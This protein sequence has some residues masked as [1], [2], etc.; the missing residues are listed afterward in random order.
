[1][2]ENESQYLMIAEARKGEERQVWISSWKRVGAGT[3]AAPTVLIEKQQIWEQDEPIL[4]VAF[5]PSG[6][7]VLSPGK[8]AL[9]GSGNEP[10]GSIPIPPMKPWP[11]DPRGRLRV[12]GN[13]FQAFL[14]GMRCTG[15]LEPA[16]T[17]ECKPS[18]EAWPLESGGRALILARLVAGRNYF[19]G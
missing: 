18:D 7:L 9:F 16:L 10:R 4:D 3:R 6:L 5:P 8:V 2:S 13:S 15:A 12:N 14:P 17:M 19:D 11:R 1:L